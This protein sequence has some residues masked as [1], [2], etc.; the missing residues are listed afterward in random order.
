MVQ[1]LD[2]LRRLQ[3][4]DD[5]LRDLRSQGEAIPRRRAALEERV[6]ELKEKLVAAEQQRE[7]TEKTRRK[8]ERDLEANSSKVQ[9]YKSQQWQVKT[10]RELEAL[11]HEVGLLEAANGDLEEQILGLF[12]ELDHCSATV[13]ER[14]TALVDQ[15]RLTA[16]RCRVLAGELIN[17]QN[18]AAALATER[19]LL[20]TAIRASLR[21]TYDRIAASR[22]GIA[23]VAVNGPACGGCNVY[24]RPQLL[25]ELRTQARLVTCESCQRIL[26][27]EQ[28]EEA[29][30]AMEG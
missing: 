14:K 6:K 23:V 15:E 27:Y 7:E 18:K 19:E 12:E 5:C 17:V 20:A 21:R 29:H 10:N 28:V 2:Q 24:L 11:R 30:E 9:R 13:Q 16:E 26:Y 4:L 3:K 22:G 8:L 25:A 1:D